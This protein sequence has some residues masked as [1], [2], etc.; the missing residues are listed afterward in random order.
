MG[1]TI[2]FDDIETEIVTKFQNQVEVCVSF[3]SPFSSQ[4]E[5]KPKI[6]KLLKFSLSSE[7]RRLNPSSFLKKAL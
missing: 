7:T 6:A 3:N 5:P 2:R 4:I 1:S